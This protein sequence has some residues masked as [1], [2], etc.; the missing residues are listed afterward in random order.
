MPSQRSCNSSIRN[1]RFM[2]NTTFH[3][4]ANEIIFIIRAFF[5]LYH[6][7]VL[8]KNHLAKCAISLCSFTQP[9]A[10]FNP[11][12]TFLPTAAVWIFLS[13][14]FW[15][16]VQIVL[17]PVSIWS[18]CWD[19]SAWLRNSFS[20]IRSARCPF[21]LFVLLSFPPFVLIQELL[22][23][24]F[25]GTDWLTTGSSLFCLWDKIVMWR[26]ELDCRTSIFKEPVVSLKRVF[27]QIT[28]SKIETSK[29]NFLHK[30]FL[31]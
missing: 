10:D 19:L 28:Y 3:R 25:N 29:E 4:A 1:Q 6:W 16:C 8:T 20:V 5:F 23:K 27:F 13:K 24:L 22:I 18:G 9:I 12:E 7:Q 11:S 17:Y 30:Y 26:Q 14:A 21:H 31:N 2:I 15:A